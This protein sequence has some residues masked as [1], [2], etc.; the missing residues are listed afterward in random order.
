[1]TRKTT[2]FEGWSWFK[3]NNLGLALGTNL[4][5]YTS[6]TKGLKL[7]VRK[8]WGLIRTF[9]EVTEEKLVGRPFCPPSILNRVKGREDWIHHPIHLRENAYAR[10]VWLASSNFC[11]FSYHILGSSFHLFE[12]Y[13]SG[14]RSILG[15]LLHCNLLK[16]MNSAQNSAELVT[17]I[18]T[19]FPICVMLMLS[20]KMNLNKYFYGIP[21][22]LNFF[23][24]FPLKSK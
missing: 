18:W 22:S 10:K 19:L 6:V 16:R 3:F 24:S 7:K 1:M 15:N 4:K 21:W 23:S 12:Y 11:K 8:F 17:I 9:A 13:F 20:I 2:F 5:F 14:N